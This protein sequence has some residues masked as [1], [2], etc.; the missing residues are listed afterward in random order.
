MRVRRLGRPEQVG[1]L[2]LR[3]RLGEQVE[4]AHDTVHSGEGAA[5]RSAGARPRAAKAARFSSRSDSLS[6][7]QVPG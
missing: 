5:R 6:V 1:E 2:R 4:A 3:G 7:R